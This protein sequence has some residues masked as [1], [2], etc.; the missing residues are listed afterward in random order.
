[1]TQPSQENGVSRG[2]ANEW[3]PGGVNAPPRP[4]E[5][6][7]RPIRRSVWVPRDET[8][9]PEPAKEAAPDVEE[10]RSE[11]KRAERRAHAAEERAERLEERIR[12][13]E[14]AAAAS[15]H[16]AESSAARAAAAAAIEET[17]TRPRGTEGPAE[18]SV[19]HL[20]TASFEALR[21]L[22]LTVSQSARFVAQREELGGFGSLDDLDRLYGLAHDVIDTLKQN[23]AV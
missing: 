14:T 22:G 2:S 4:P 16:A 19:L 7:A 9:R 23:C 3:L 10:L 13:L 8:H 6:I 11:L 15:R 12:Q 1:M 5:A 17:A 18:D 21:A 20:N